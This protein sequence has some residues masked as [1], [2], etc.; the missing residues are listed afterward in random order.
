MGKIKVKIIKETTDPMCM[1]VSI[2]GLKEEGYYLVYRG[3][4]MEDIENMLTDTLEAFK[5][6]RLSGN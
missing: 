2:G 3:D 6:A 4:N 1:R 5:R